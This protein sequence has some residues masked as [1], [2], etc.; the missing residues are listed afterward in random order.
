MADGTKYENN[1][2]AVINTTLQTAINHPEIAGRAIKATV[3][4]NN[5]ENPESHRPAKGFNMW[6][7]I[8]LL[9]L[10]LLSPV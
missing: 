3:Q 6:L 10:Y 4:N 5:R 8:N 7:K 1:V 9:M 2:L